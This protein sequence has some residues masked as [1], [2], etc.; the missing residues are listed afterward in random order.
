[1]EYLLVQRMWN[2]LDNVKINNRSVMKMGFEIHALDAGASLYAYMG[3][4]RMCEEQG[5]DW[6]SLINANDCNGG[7]SGMGKGKLIKLK[8]FENAL[9]VLINHK[10]IRSS[11]EGRD[12]WKHRKPL[13]REFM[14]RC[15]KWCKKNK[16]NSIYV[17]F[18]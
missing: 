3:A 10:P 8:D 5:Y 15:I 4:F 18:G 13:L 6:F 16:R 17:F 9:S 1:M 11:I 7:V 14:E 12:E 2:I